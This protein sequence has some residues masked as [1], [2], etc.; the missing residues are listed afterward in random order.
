MYVGEKK[1]FLCVHK[2][3][4]QINKVFGAKKLCTYVFRMLGT[5]FFLRRT[6][7]IGTVKKLFCICIFIWLESP[8]PGGMV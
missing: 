2:K 7:V 5:N 8:L 4:C 1:V 6:K 3:V